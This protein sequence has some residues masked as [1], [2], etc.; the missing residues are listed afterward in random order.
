M[1]RQRV[2]ARRLPAAR[3]V[4]RRTRPIR[5]CGTSNPP[6]GGTA[7]LHRPQGHRG[8]RGHERI[9]EQCQGLWTDGQTLWISARYMLWRFENVLAAGATTPQGA[10]DGSG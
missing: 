2:S 7:V 4:H 3:D 8:V 6:L 10:D 5:E 9:I 1:L